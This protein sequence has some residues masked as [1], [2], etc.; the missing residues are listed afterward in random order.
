M[1]ERSRLEHHVWTLA[2]EIGERNVFHP[3]ALA[4]ARDYIVQQWRAQGLE[5]RFQRY[6]TQGVES[7]NLEV[8]L[9]GASRAS[10]SIVVGAHYD[11]VFGSPGAD[12]NASAVAV[13]LELSRAIAPTLRARTLRLVAFV[14]EEPPFFY[15]GE[16]GSQVYARAAR[17]RGEDIRVMV[18]LEMLGYY[19]DEPR[20]Q[21]YPPFLRWFYP[22]RGNFIGFVSNLRSRA[23]LL[24]VH[25]AFCSHCAFPSERAAVPS[26]IP[27]VGWSDHLSFWREGYRA[28][29]VTDTAFY[30]YPYYH[31]ALDTPEKVDYARLNEVANGLAGALMELA[32]AE[33][34]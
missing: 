25:R 28:L 20:S 26:W 7:S 4:A 34:L 32:E 21:R 30:R 33:V 19:R 29:M 31:T 6:L 13:L 22:D 16:M 5:P 8:I 11:S 23:A 18:S 1:I 14:N 9:E 15:W 12:D 27:G 3:D 24:R 17:R 2:G 10:Q